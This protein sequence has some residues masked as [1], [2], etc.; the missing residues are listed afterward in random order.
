[1]RRSSAKTALVVV[2]VAAVEVVVTALSV[3]GNQAASAV[4]SLLAIGVGAFAITAVAVFG[5][6]F[7]GRRLSENQP[8]PEPW[9]WRRPWFAAGLAS[10]LAMGI[11]AALGVEVLLTQPGRCT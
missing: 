7:I 2:A 9:A 8:D 10:V 1:M 11:I 6:R 3:C 5:H 4:G